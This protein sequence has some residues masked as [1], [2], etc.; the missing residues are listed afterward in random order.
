MQPCREVLGDVQ[1]GHDLLTAAGHADEATSAVNLTERKN[2][3][4]I[5]AKMFRATSEGKHIAARYGCFSWCQFMQ[6]SSMLFRKA[7]PVVLCLSRQVK[8]L[9]KICA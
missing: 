6:E 4:N 5:A 1:V 2:W 9:A 7:G 3:L 8:S